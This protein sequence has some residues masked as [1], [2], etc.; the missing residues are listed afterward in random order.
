MPYHSKTLRA[1][2][3]LV[4]LLTATACS[5]TDSVN[6]E[7]VLI[8]HPATA[9]DTKSDKPGN[10]ASLA[11]AGTK[12]DAHSPTARLIPPSA[13]PSELAVADATSTPSINEPNENPLA[14]A[15]MDNFDSPESSQDQ[16]AEA[17]DISLATWRA[18]R[19]HM[20]SQVALGLAY[21]YGNGVE[22]D[23]SQA[24]LWLEL[25]SMKGHSRAQYELGKL[26]YTGQG[27][28][29]DYFN[30][31]EW[32]LESALQ[33][34]LDAQQKLGYLYSEGLG[35]KRDYNKAKQWYSRAAKSG[36][37]EAQT[38][39]G[40]LYH[41]GNRI[42]TDYS[43]AF[44]WYK[45]AAEQGHPYAQYTLA[46]LYHDGFGT[47]VDYIQCAAWVEVAVA[48]GFDDE[49]YDAGQRCRD[50]LTEE[51]SRTAT[52]LADTWKRKYLSRGI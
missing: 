45:L 8:D 34:D 37:A 47:Q 39:L 35:V 40:S 12:P 23:P 9:T 2:Y 26:F 14:S 43:E 19:G 6:P 38:L 1:A 28:S 36:H 24:K 41:E 44:K 32:W 42:P 50:Q 31:R 7:D 3:V 5:T 17:L 16:Q 52:H 21:A 18:E 27:V 4:T 48:N 25:A 13:P 33:G 22:Q 51:S 20:E 15:A 30:A 29:K 11:Q 46:T 10:N 49:E